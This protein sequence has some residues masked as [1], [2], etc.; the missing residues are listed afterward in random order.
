[1]LQIIEGL[2]TIVAG[3]VAALVDFPETAKFLTEEEKIYVI[4]RKKF[5]NSS[6]G[7][8][9][10]FAFRH[11]WAAVFDWQTWIHVIMNVS[12]IGPDHSVKD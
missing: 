8:E 5:D 10:H 2:T 4:W 7:E 9:E 3:V 11:I 1:M 12:V 6:V